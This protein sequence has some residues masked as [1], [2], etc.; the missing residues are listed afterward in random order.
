MKTFSFLQFFDE[1]L[2]FSDPF[3][4]PIFRFAAYLTSAKGSKVVGW[5]RRETYAGGNIL[6]ART[7]GILHKV[8]AGIGGNQRRTLYLK[9]ERRNRRN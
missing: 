7:G 8:N 2:V 9:N 5:D 4:T 1:F 6:Y 3:S